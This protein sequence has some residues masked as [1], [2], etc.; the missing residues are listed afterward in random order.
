MGSESADGEWVGETV[1]FQL[2]PDWFG[3]M[4]HVAVSKDGTRTFTTYK[5]TLEWS[6]PDGAVTSRWSLPVRAARSLELLEE[7]ARHWLDTVVASPYHGPVG[8]TL[9]R[10]T[11]TRHRSIEI[12]LLNLDRQDGRFPA[13][14]LGDVTEPPALPGARVTYSVWAGNEGGLVQNGETTFEAAVER[15]KALATAAE[16]GRLRLSQHV[17]T[18]DLWCELPYPVSVR[19]AHDPL[20]GLPT[21][22]SETPVPAHDIAIPVDRSLVLLA[23]DGRLLLATEG[24]AWLQSSGL[25]DV[26]VVCEGSDI[27][28][29]VPSDWTPAGA[30]WPHDVSGVPLSF[31]AART[32]SIGEPITH[33]WQC[34]GAEWHLVAHQHLLH[35]SRS[36]DGPDLE[37]F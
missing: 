35:G 33:L 18:D 16:Y 34:V 2:P 32:V 8:G 30:V 5:M 19:A 15:F 6:T 28:V 10:V 26:G 31:D 17:R 12:H 11:V 22:P 4:G 36:P 9:T 21:T 27:H 13:G 25:I 1:V 7:R 24:L 20:L 14:P 37:L 3:P 29:L 23:P